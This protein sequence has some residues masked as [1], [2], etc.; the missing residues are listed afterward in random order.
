MCTHSQTVGKRPI[1]LFYRGYV[2]PQCMVCDTTKHIEFIY[3][4]VRDTTKRTIF[5]VLCGM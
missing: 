4:V 1:D 3:Y 2:I 5:M